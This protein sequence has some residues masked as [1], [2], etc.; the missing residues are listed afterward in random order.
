MIPKAELDLPSE[1]ISEFCRRWQVTELSLFGSVL[2]DDFDSKSDL[3]ILVSFEQDAAWS[4]VDLVRME[5]ELETLLKHD[6]DIVERQSVEKSTNYI[7]RKH[8]LST[9]EPF[10]VAG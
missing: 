9:A 5:E 4:L 3:D 10:Y 2:R 8:I 6:V 1:T 7:R